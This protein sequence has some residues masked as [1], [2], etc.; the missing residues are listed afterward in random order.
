LPIKRKVSGCSDGAKGLIGANVAGRPL[1]ADVLFANLQRQHE[2][3][4]TLCV[5]SFANQTP[6]H[7]ADELTL[8][9]E[10]A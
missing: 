8:A 3:T 7:F 4:L 1:A 2:P 6:G 10:D 9:S 5:N